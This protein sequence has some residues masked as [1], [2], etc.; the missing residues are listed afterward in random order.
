M[1][2]RDQT[3]TAL[4]CLHPDQYGLARSLAERCELSIPFVASADPSRSAGP[5]LNEFFPRAEVVRDLR[6][7]LAAA[8]IGVVILGRLPGAS[9]RGA[10]GADAALDAHEAIRLC[11]ERGIRVISFEP[12]PTALGEA[13]DAAAWGDLV[14]LVPLLRDARLFAAASDVLANFGPVRSVSFAARSGPGQGTLGARLFDA[15]LLVHSLLGLPESI[16]C[17]IVSPGASVG[18]HATPADSLSR[19][20]GDLTANIRF[21]GHCAASISLSDR[22]GRW[23]RGATLLGES[24]CL[25]IDESGFEVID[26][27]GRTIDRSPAKAPTKA[28]RGTEPDPLAS[29]VDVFAEAIDR[30][31]DERVPRPAP[32]DLGAVLSM[33]EAA[34]LSARTGQAESPATMLRMN[35]LH[36][37][38]LA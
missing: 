19:L 34:M 5:E 32:M 1:P 7:A 8:D 10:A 21:A 37:S 13:R 20:A 3:R 14:R 23:F 24:G 30:V 22:A 17:S 18:L 36:D 6:H 25:R 2:A 27:S 33:C 35:A 28:A 16:D 4:I 11:V 38:G 26:P 31:L 29:A 15:M 12:V 9:F